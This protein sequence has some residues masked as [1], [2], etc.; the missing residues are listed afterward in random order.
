[1]KEYT[2]IQKKKAYKMRAPLQEG[3]PA[4]Q[5]NRSHLT[6]KKTLTTKFLVT[7]AAHNLYRL[8]SNSPL[9]SGSCMLEMHHSIPQG[10]A[11]YWVACKDVDTGHNCLYSWQI[12]GKLFDTF[13]NQEVVFGINFK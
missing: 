11:S 4:M 1:M 7:F 6:I 3:T 2:S 10:C 5:N 8:S 9:A 12:W 13:I